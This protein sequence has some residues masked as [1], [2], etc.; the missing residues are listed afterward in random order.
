LPILI[1]NNAMAIIGLGHT[2][3]A[4]CRKVLEEDDEI[5]ATTH[6]V[7]SPFDFFY[8]FSDAAFHK[9]CLIRWPLRDAFVARYNYYGRAW[10]SRMRGDGSVVRE[11]APEVPEPEGLYPGD[12]ALPLVCS[13]RRPGWHV[14]FNASFPQVK[15]AH[16]IISVE[17]PMP[18]DRAR[19]LLPD[20][21]LVGPI[22]HARSLPTSE[23]HRLPLRLLPEIPGDIERVGTRPAYP[24]ENQPDCEAHYAEMCGRERGGLP[25]GPKT[26]YAVHVTGEFQAASV[27]GWAL[28][29]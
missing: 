26:A 27:R 11:T 29:C 25:L 4:L 2:P 16:V 13:E 22:E 20:Q 1:R 21:V 14:L 24:G 7:L 15:S 19:Q 6:F 3:C 10:G 18:R 8:A 23:E 5:V 12:V 28:R 17:V 9:S